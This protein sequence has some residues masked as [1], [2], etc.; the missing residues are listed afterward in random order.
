MVTAVITEQPPTNSGGVNVGGFFSNPVFGF[1]GDHFFA[2]FFLLI[3][4]VLVGFFIWWWMT[5]EED[6]RE[7]EDM[8][9]KEFK[10]TVRSCEKNSDPQKYTK[11]YSKWNFILLG[12]PVFHYRRGAKIFDAYKTFKG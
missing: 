11:H 9:Y 1:I 3:L 4:A 2:I 7:Q 10:D 12:I 8:L 5:K 6:L